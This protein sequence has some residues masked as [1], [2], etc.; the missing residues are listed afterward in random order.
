MYIY[1]WLIGM[2]ALLIVGVT[3]YLKGDVKA[4]FKMLGIELSIE[5]KERAAQPPTKGTPPT[6]G[7]VPY[8]ETTS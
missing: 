5:A 7:L 6:T 1:M 4:G 2:S 3:L 8:F